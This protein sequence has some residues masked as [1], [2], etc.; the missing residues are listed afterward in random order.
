MITA[1]VAEGERMSRGED[2]M[3]TSPGGGGRWWAAVLAACVLSGGLQSSPTW[4]PVA[5][6]LE[7]AITAFPDTAALAE[8]VHYEITVSNAGSVDETGVTLEVSVPEKMREIREDR[9]DGGECI[10]ENCD[11]G[12]SITWQL[13]RLR[14][15]QSVTKEVVMLLKSATNG[16]VLLSTA[17][18]TNTSG[19]GS[20]QTRT[21]V[22]DSRPVL[23]LNLIEDHE[24][25]EPGEEL[26]YRLAFGNRG[27]QDAPGTILSAT[28][29]AGTRLVAISDAGIL[30]EGHVRWQLGTV[31]IGE[32]GQRWFRVAVEDYVANGSILRAAA[33]MQTAAS[34]DD[35]ARASVATA[36]QDVTPLEVN[37][38][39]TPDTVAPGDSVT[40]R[41]TVTNTSQMDLSGVAL[42]SRLPAKMET[43]PENLTDGG[44]CEGITLV[45]FPSEQIEWSLGTLLA[46]QRITKEVTM[47][48]AGGATPNPLPSLVR[49]VDG[50]LIL[51]SVRATAEGGW[52]ALQ[53]IAVRICTTEGTSCD[54]HAPADVGGLLENPDPDSFQSGAGVIAGWRCDAERIDIVIDG[55]MFEAAYGTSREDTRSICGDADN[56]FGL[57]VNWN[58]FG[59]GLHDVRA[60]ADG[61]EFARARLTVSTFGAEFLTGVTGQYGLIDFPQT[62][63]ITPLQ[64]QESLQNFVIGMGQSEGEGSPGDGTGVLENPQSGS[65]HSGAGIISG[66]RCAAERIDVE[67][68]G[69]LFQTAYGTSREDTRS[70]CGDADNG[71]GVLVNWNLFGAGQHD[72]RAIADGFEFAS[73][74]ITVTTFG[75]EFLSGVSGQYELPD[76]PEPGQTTTVRWQ[77]PIQN[78]V[79]EHVQ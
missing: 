34:P 75:V 62:G 46:G 52:Q 3:Q 8:G 40:Y 39:A 56:G 57:L 45:C 31:G 60:L 44:L 27:M 30:A 78:F 26:T 66:W 19:S 23:T 32:G 47:V 41:M 51:N 70:L 12:E 65:F 6:A 36:V 74:T 49:V 77:E 22:A 38:T 53:G 54:Q 73:A 35:T 71:F 37:M 55:V 10:G 50:T 7:V 21:I 59:G 72:V 18:V 79:I 1:E 68:D 13:G 67:I 25:A 33:E 29:P 69:V 48:V 43:L 9:T 24:P 14:A 61:I 76:F 16:N 20:I 42:T 28:V 15:G 5:H 4:A 2:G 64:W 17:Q 58:L 63:M 11:P